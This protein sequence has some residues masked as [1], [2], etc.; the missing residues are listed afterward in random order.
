MSGTAI[1]V[2]PAFTTTYTLV[3]V[4]DANGCTSAILTPSAGNLTGSAAVTVRDTVEILTQPKHALVCEGIDTSFTVGAIGDGLQ[5][6]WETTDD[7][8]NPD[9]L[10]YGGATSAT[11][12]CDCTD[13]GH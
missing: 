11:Y 3:S 7:L 9:L 13:C 2:S 8:A 1:P 6:Q 12:P 4:V 5:Y 10:P